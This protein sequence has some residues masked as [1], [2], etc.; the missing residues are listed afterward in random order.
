MSKPIEIEFNEKQI[1]KDAGQERVDFWENVNA[2]FAALTYEQQVNYFLESGFPMDEAL[3]LT[4]KARK[5]KLN[6]AI[7][8]YAATFEDVKFVTALYMMEKVKYI[9]SP[10]SVRC[11]ALYR[12]SSYNVLCNRINE[13]F[14]MM[15]PNSIRMSLGDLNILKDQKFTS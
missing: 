4:D 1:L 14:G 15:L 13:I 8:S 6:V 12:Q 3:E 10:V 2:E 9:Q 7:F 11:E 5:K